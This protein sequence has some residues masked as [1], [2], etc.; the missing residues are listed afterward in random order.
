M[1][2]KASYL[3]ENGTLSI[4]ILQKPMFLTEAMC[5]NALRSLL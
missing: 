4:N 2:V 5:E 1:G 3:Y